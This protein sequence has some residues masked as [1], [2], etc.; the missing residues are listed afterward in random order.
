MSLFFLIE[1]WVYFNN[2]T[3]VLGASFKGGLRKRGLR[4]KELRVRKEGLSEGTKKERRTLTEGRT[5]KM[6]D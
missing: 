5:I 6:K 3:R 1:W 4:K 2:L